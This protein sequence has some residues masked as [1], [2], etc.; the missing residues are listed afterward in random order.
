MLLKMRKCVLICKQKYKNPYITY[1]RTRDENTYNTNGRFHVNCLGPAHYQF[2]FSQH[3]H[4]WENAQYTYYSIIQIYFHPI[5]LENS[6]CNVC[7]QN[8]TL[9]SIKYCF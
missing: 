3:A 7:T 1:G 9:Y 2:R 8:I 6:Y 4:K 5:F